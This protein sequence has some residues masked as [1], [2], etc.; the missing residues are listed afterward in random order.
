VFASAVLTG[1]ERSLDV[2]PGADH[3]GA[4]QSIMVRFNR[5]RG[6]TV[7]HPN[8]DLVREGYAAFGRGDIEALQSRFF[9]PDIRWHFPGRSPFAGDY[10]GMAEVLGWLGRSAEASGGT[11]RIDLHDVIGNDDHV[12]ALVTV[13]AERGGK[14]L[15]DNSVQVFHVRDGKAAEVWTYPANV[16][17]EDDFW[18]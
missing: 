4:I 15:D 1:G 5:S 14:T 16:Y 18:S 6:D 13:R 8:E 9:A 3:H 17:A 11:L 12:V 2:V 7:A 10:T